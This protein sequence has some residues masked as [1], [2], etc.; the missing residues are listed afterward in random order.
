MIEVKRSGV[1]E[2]NHR[3]FRTRRGVATVQ[4]R[5]QDTLLPK[6]NNSCAMVRNLHIATGRSRLALPD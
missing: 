1:V 5:R 2:L 6:S 3:E 4:N